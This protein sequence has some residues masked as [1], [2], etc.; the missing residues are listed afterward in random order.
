MK[1]IAAVGIGRMGRGIAICFAFSGHN[2][3]LVDLKKRDKT[4]FTKLI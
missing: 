2:V 1:T 4:D 3:Q